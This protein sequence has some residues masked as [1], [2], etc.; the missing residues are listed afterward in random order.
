MMSFN[1]TH[2]LPTP[3]PVFKP[4]R[5]SHCRTPSLSSTSSTGVSSTEDE[6]Q[7]DGQSGSSPFSSNDDA[8]VIAT[9]EPESEVETEMPCELKTPLAHIMTPTTPTDRFTKLSVSSRLAKGEAFSHRRQ[10]SVA[11]LRREVKRVVSIADQIT[12]G[13]ARVTVSLLPLVSEGII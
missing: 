13:H 11:G 2:L 12:F 6:A 9:S 1:G 3:L 10:R 5:I 4:T 7:T 8:S